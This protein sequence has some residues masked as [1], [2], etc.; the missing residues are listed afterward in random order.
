MRAMD[1][2]DAILSPFG[3]GLL[4]ALVLW[5]SWRRLPR[6]LRIFGVA[7]G[8]VCLA[9]TTKIGASILVAA[10]ER[11]APSA[12]S[13]AAPLPT[14]VVLLAGG[15][16]RLPQS[17]TDYDALSAASVRRTIDAVKLVRD[18]HADTLVITG[19]GEREHVAESDVM[20]E[21]ARHLGMDT[22]TIRTET[23]S[24][25]TWENAQ[26][27]RALDPA[28]L[29]RIWLVTSALHMRRAMIAFEAAGF[30]PCAYPTDF[31]ASPFEGPTDLLPT[32]GAAANAA[33]ALHE[34]VG[35]IEYRWRAARK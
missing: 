12:E 20:A 6:V 29:P 15:V 22:A 34:I 27:A 14:T 28:V 31:I 1:I 16:R 35:E 4:L 11:R 24:L 21:L 26:R 33:M 17:S 10:V 13:C 23:A 32:G 25:N 9:L 2:V 7:L 18:R 8:I 19:G 30:E 5:L 3:G